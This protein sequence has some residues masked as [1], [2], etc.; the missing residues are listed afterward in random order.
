LSTTA[1]PTPP[2]V[3]T[4]LPI[5]TPE[6]A[7]ALRSAVTDGADLL[8]AIAEG[9]TAEI[10]DVLRG[11]APSP[12]SMADARAVR[13]NYIYRAAKARSVVVTSDHV[14]AV[15]RLTPTA[16]ASTIRRVHALYPLEREDRLDESMKRGSRMTD[17][18]SGETRVHFGDP[19]VTDHARRVLAREGL[20]AAV[21]LDRMTGELLVPAEVEVPS[22][23]GT[24]RLD[25]TTVYLG[26][27]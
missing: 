9:V 12:S 17:P 3:S 8:A 18:S 13:L 25:P 26:I 15:F 14:E 6:A 1:L 4:T 27:P 2:V 21:R 19:A 20:V 23:G 16:A 22:A 10:F 11:V 7:Q 5:H 24:K